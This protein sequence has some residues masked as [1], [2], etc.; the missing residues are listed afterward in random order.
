MGFFKKKFKKKLPLSRLDDIKND[1]V[2]RFNVSYNNA[3]NMIDDFVDKYP[4][5]R[6]WDKIQVS[7]NSD[8]ETVAITGFYGQKVFVGIS[9]TEEEVVYNFETELIE[10]LGH[11]VDDN[12]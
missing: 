1:L 6:T 8:N 5:W 7:V 12:K 10:I 4:T 9:N 11:E 3:D 2:F